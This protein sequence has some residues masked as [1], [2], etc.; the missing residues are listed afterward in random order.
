MFGWRE[1][2]IEVACGLAA[3]GLRKTIPSSSSPLLSPPLLAN[4][5]ALPDQYRW[6]RD[7]LPSV[8]IGLGPTQQIKKLFMRIQLLPTETA[9]RLTAA[10]FLPTVVECVVE[11]ILNSIDAGATYIDV[12]LG[13]SPGTVSVQ[14]SDNGEGITPDDMDLVGRRGGNEGLGLIN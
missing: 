5:G 13:I 7:D 2:F 6:T 1:S 12:N 9:D 4:C 14:V 8:F 11:L 3:W 10:A